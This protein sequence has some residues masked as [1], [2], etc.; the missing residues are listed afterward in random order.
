MLSREDVIKE[1]ENEIGNKNVIID[2]DMSR[3]TSFKAGGR[4]YA[5]VCPN[6]T[7]RLRNTLK[8]LARS[9]IPYE[10]FGNGTNTLVAD[11]GYS[12]VIVRI[13]EAFSEIHVDEEELTA[14]AGA[15]LSTVSNEALKA[16]LFGLE[17]AAGIPGSIGGAVFMNAG[18]YGNEMKNIVKCVNIISRDGGSEFTKRNSEMRF[19][20]RKSLLHET[21]DAATG[22]TLKLCRGSEEAIREKMTEYGALRSERQPL[23][24]PSA[25]SFFRR[26]EGHYAG[27]LIEDAGLKGLTLGGASVSERHAGFI[28]NNKDATATD[29]IDLMKIVQLTVR[30]KFGVVLEPEVRIIGD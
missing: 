23:S 9:G 29:I 21:G 27:K 7:L 1:I 16:G 10:F 15:L 8:I 13:G 4:A 6:D 25:G 17:F 19:E 5:L 12:G 30:D 28:V 2:C 26:P 11:N 20:Y 24:L 3:F 14:G 18:A 22:V